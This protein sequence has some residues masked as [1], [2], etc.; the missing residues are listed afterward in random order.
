MSPESLAAGQLF[1]TILIEGSSDPEFD[2]PF[3]VLHKD[4]SPVFKYSTRVELFSFYFLYMS[5]FV[6][7]C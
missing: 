7:A 5:G 2:A 6:L 4:A 3:Y 1:L